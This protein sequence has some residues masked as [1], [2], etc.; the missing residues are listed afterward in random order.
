ML[1]TGEQG[2]TINLP[3]MPG[4]KGEVGVPGLTGINFTVALYVL[5]SHTEVHRG[6]EGELTMGFR[7]LLNLCPHDSS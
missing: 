7:W 4:L 3:G 2:E 6:R 1:E 5:L